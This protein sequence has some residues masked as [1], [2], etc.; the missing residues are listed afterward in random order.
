MAFGSFL[1]VFL[2]VFFAFQSVFAAETV[3]VG[4]NAD[5]LR[6]YRSFVKNRDPLKITK[7]GG[8]YSRR[9]VVEV[10]LFMQALSRGKFQG[11]VEL[12]P[13]PST[14]RILEQVRLGKVT[15]LAN[16][17]WSES[18][19]DGDVYKT[20]PLIHDG[21]FVVGIYTRPE[22]AKL[23][24]AKFPEDFAKFSAV[25]SPEWHPD[26]KALKA[27]QVGHVFEVSQWELM[28]KMVSSGRVDFTLAPFRNSQDK[29]FTDGSAVFVP[30]RNYKVNLK[31]TRHWVSS[32]KHPAGLQ[33]HEVLE[34]GRQILAQEGTI[35]RAYRESGFFQDDIADWKLLNP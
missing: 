3:K 18:L 13:L 21:E 4:L 32:K 19:A 10:V 29:R 14:G 24:K 35:R 8:P 1:F 33:M 16:S 20:K 23:L 30:V 6:D 2:L 22:N 25:T 31:G 9:D 17:A 26:V 5:I 28:V 15:A 34:K 7:F 12:V 11:V 27:L